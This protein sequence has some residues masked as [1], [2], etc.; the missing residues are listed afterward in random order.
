MSYFKEDVE[1]NFENGF[2]PIECYRKITLSHGPNAIRKS[3]VRK[4]FRDLKAVTFTHDR[5]KMVS[6]P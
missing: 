4:Y 5:K 6:R 1:W 3:T 2:S